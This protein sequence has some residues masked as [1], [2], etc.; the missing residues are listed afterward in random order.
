MEMLNG[1]GTNNKVHIRMSHAEILE[2]VVRK[3]KNLN[4]HPVR[5]NRKK[6]EVE[7]WEHVTM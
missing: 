4:L 5:V 6:L 1:N 3:Y 7:S 2:Y